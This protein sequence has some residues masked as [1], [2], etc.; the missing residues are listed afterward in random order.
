MKMTAMQAAVSVLA[1]EGV[2][3][4]FGVPG[5]AIEGGTHAAEGYSRAVSGNVGVCIGTSGPAERIWSR[6][7]IPPLLTA[8]PSSASRAKLHGRSCIRRI[9]RQSMWPRSLALSPSGLQFLIEELAVAAQYKIPFV[10]VLFNN[11]YLGLIRQG[12]RSYNMDFEVQRSFHNINAPEIGDYGVDHVRAAEAFGCVA[13]RVFK[14][15]DLADAM[16]WARKTSVER[17]VPALV[18]VITERVTNI[19]MGAEIDKITEFE[20]VLDMSPVT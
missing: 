20:E 2:E 7:C 6:G 4:A 19:A 18:E 1:N 12:E 16:R 15:G 5:A 17:Q 9:S 8:F 3:A 14:P 13:R 11:A 10:L